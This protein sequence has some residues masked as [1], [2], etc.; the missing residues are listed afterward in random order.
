MMP[1]PDEVH[2]PNLDQDDGR[3]IPPPSPGGGNGQP[4][5]LGVFLQ[6]VEIAV[7]VIGATFTA[8]DLSN[9]YLPQLDI[10]AGVYTTVGLDTSQTE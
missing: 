5:A 3:Q 9:G 10:A 8:A 4:A 2:I 1:V 6:R 7:K